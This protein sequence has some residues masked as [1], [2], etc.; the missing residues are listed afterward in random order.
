MVV[1]EPNFV[2]QQQGFAN[3]QA[4]RRVNTTKKRNNRALWWLLLLIVP[5]LVVTAIYLVGDAARPDYDVY[6][7]YGGQLY[8]AQKD[9]DLLPVGYEY[10]DTLSFVEDMPD[11]DGQCNCSVGMLYMKP[12]K[13]KTVYLKYSNTPEAYWKCTRVSPEK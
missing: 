12:G 10:A 1:Q 4:M 9:T 7:M 11:T 5:V 13:T 2:A 8:R 6:A 3:A